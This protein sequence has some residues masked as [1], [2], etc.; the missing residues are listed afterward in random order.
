MWKEWYLVQKIGMVVAIFLLFFS[1]YIFCGVL[2][3]WEP[4]FW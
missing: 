4:P 3:G 1:I 2:F